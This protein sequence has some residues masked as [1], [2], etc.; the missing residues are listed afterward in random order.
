[1]LQAND[2]L[3]D[4]EIEVAQRN[5]LAVIAR[6]RAD[7]GRLP[8]CGQSI[9]KICVE[10]S[11]DDLVIHIKGWR[12]LARRHQSTSSASILGH[13]LCLH[14]NDD[15][16]IDQLTRVR[17]P[18]KRASRAD[19]RKM[20]PDRSKIAKRA[21]IRQRCCLEGEYAILATGLL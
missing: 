11:V 17:H 10:K 5:S 6:D 8:A 15:P 20:Q 7:Y 16:N 2:L 18:P 14:L 9:E 19:Q 4:Q 1:M 13:S 12:R 3:I 21:P